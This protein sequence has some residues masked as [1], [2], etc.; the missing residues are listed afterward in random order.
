MAKV[1]PKRIGFLFIFALIAGVILFFSQSIV[2]TVEGGEIHVKQAAISGN[3]TIR[4]DEGLY[5]QMFGKITKYFRTFETYLSNDALDGGS[6]SD[7]AA[8]TVRFGDG[9]TAEIGSVTQWRMPLTDADVIKIHRNYRSFTSLA[10]QVRQWVIEVEKQTASTF[11]ADE[12]YSTRRGEFSQLITDQIANGLY[13][14]TTEEVNV[15]TNETDD[16][17]NSVMATVTK[18]VIKTDET[19]FPII[20]KKGIF[21]EYSLELVNHTLK[22]I[23]YDE[24][25]DSLIAQKKKAEQEKAV[26]ITNAEKAIQDALTAEAQGEADIAK[27]RATEEVKKITDVTQQEAKKAV[28]ILNAQQKLEVAQLDKQAAAEAA[29]ARLITER[30]EADANLL[31]VRAG[32]TPQQ[33]AEWDYKIADVVSRNLASVDLPDMMIFGGGEGSPMNPWDA[34]GLESFMK[35]SDKITNQE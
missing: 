8:T 12:T 17:G 10:A 1:N 14:T 18:V 9:G 25:I 13:Q 32:L 30:A 23:D 21:Q 19:G 5:M 26:A 20:V 11:K 34:V 6:G 28:A 4:T 2:E 7:T 33:K 27:A 16:E 3:M 24:T 31:K 35:I 29:S 22:D 15:L